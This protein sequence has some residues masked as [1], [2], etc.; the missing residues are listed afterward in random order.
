MGLRVEGVVDGGV[1]YEEALGGPSGF[2]PLLLALSS[3]DR[4][5]RVLG[6]VVV[7]QSSW[8]VTIAQP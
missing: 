8:S 6:T 2:E 1:S 5:M 7:S 4:Q 3:P